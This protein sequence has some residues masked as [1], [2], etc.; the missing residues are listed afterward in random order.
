MKPAPR[1]SPIRVLLAVLTKFGPHLRQQR[2][3]LA[4]GVAAMLVE[5]GLRLLEPWALK[6]VFDGMLQQG[7]A[8]G[9]AHQL[10][11]SLGGREA[12]LLGTCLLVVVASGLRATAAYWSTVSFASAGSRVLSNVRAEL[13][14]HLQCLSLSFHHRSR[15]GDLVMRV[16]NDVKQLQ[17]VLATALIPMLAKTL[18]VG[19]MAALMFVMNL[20]LACLAVALLPLFWLRGIQCGRR[21]HSAARA[22]RRREGDMAATAAE[23]LGA[24]HVVQALSLEQRFADAFGERNQHALKED[25]R[26][27]RL[28]AQLER[29]VD[30]F[31][32]IASALVLW[33][34]T[35]LI[36]ESRITPGDLLVFLAYLKTAFRPLQDSA[37]YSGRLAKAAAAAERVLNIL[38]EG[39]LVRNR[40][41]AIT[42]PPFRGEVEF[43]DV[44]FRYPSEDGRGRGLQS[45]NFSV[46]P[47]QLAAL[48]GHSGSGKSTLLALISRLYDPQ[49]GSVR[50]DGHDLRE[51]IVEGVRSQVSVVLQDTG[52]FAL[53]VADNI[54]AGRDN[55]SDAEVEAA[56]RLANAHEF[57]LQLPQGYQTLLGERGVTLSH[58]QRQRIAIARAALRKS[59]ILLLDEPTSGLDEASAK[60]VFEALR[61]LCSQC[62]AIMAT[63]DLH[64]A[65]EADV[66]FHVDHGHVTAGRGAHCCHPEMQDDRHVQKEDLYALSR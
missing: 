41:D 26:G 1:L 63:H 20:Q 17:D 27:K 19:G 30:V 5:V 16:V 56:A 24:A 60:A 66:V 40:P 23:C 14:R 36:W 52:L 35:R 51:F 57:I 25:V 47:G 33:Q 44:T 15:S 43:E 38:D 39:A 11:T 55:A 45:V 61:R 29:S 6:I 46:A 9:L 2:R 4:V 22:Q 12:V 49:Q 50:I 64:Q 37:K 32:A 8:A 53:S 21:I 48:V 3:L 58:G 13:F 54:R 10:T 18:L 59:P 31:I 7:T 28:S 42:P 65:S 62:T 34:G